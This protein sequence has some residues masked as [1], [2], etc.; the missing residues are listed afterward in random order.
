NGRERRGSRKR[1]RWRTPRRLRRSP[2]R[3]HGRRWSWQ[4]SFLFGGA[5]GSRVA[6]GTSPT[7]W[8]KPRGGNAL[9]TG[10][11]DLEHLVSSLGLTPRCGGLRCDD[12]QCDD[13]DAATC[14]ATIST[15]EGCAA[16]DEHA[17][18]GTAT[19]RPWPV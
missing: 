9:L 16:E 1:W 17:R 14:A 11:R 7:L 6:R 19:V 3:S 2:D 4:S 13:L 15:G 12:Q 5:R 10:R 18:V 8:R